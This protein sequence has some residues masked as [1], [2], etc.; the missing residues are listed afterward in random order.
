M[1]EKV[2]LNISGMT[3]ADCV[4]R[5]EEGLRQTPGILQANVNFATEKAFIEYDA[6]IIDANDLQNKIRD[7][8]YEAFI[9][10]GESVSRPD[11]VTISVGGMTCAAC[12]R[13][14]E[15]ALKEVEG[16]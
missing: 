11:K 12:V 9:D 4:R 13:R 2:T 14:V 1:A 5:I 6:G 7:L 8:G 16:V 3:C 10:A 15:N